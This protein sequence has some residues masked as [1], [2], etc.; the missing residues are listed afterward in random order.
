MIDPDEPAPG[1]MASEVADISETIRRALAAAGLNG[2]SEPLQGTGHTVRQTLPSANLNTRRAPTSRKGVLKH[3]LGKLP[4]RPPKLPG[5]QSASTAPAEQAL[6]GQFASRSFA[7]P[8]G[9]LQY[10][11]YIPSN[12]AARSNKTYPLIVMLHGCKQS[13]DDFAAGTRM[14]ALAE[15]HGF[16]VAY[17]AQPVAANGSKCW[18][19]F[20]A[21]DQ[22]R[23][24]G[25]P[26][27]IAGI[28]REVVARYRVDERRI[29][30]A[31]LSA[32]AAMAVVLGATYPDLYAGV[33]AH[34][35]VAYGVAHDMPSAFSAM[36]S[37][38]LGPGVTNMPGV[39]P[40]QRSVA[41]SVP[42]IV[43]HGDRDNTVHMQNGVEIVE[44]ATA[45]G[46]GKPR[47]TLNTERGVASDGGT[48]T[49]TVYKDG[50][51][52]FVEYWLLHGAGHAWSGG[53]PNGSFTDAHGPD[54]SSEMIRFFYSQ[55]G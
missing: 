35:G 48:F 4:A 9:A 19:W 43:F 21:E 5:V 28:T 41:L 26:S 54:A 36:R 47:L 2:P 40:P 33:G 1:A 50:N 45:S 30:V 15:K 25:E 13:P 39:H 31:G 20:R 44:H 55:K 42:T 24:L 18:N 53:S 6:P 17:P 7:G 22:G 3:L 38:S 10:K 49:R 34:S 37:G 11:L 12:Y 52:P 46:K 16:L 51:R 29:F 27:L 23:D 8:A 32:G 14:N